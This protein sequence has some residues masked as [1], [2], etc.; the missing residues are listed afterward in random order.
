M[1]EI[2][3]AANVLLTTCSNCQK[4]EK[5]LF[6]TDPTSYEIAK[7]VYDAAKDFPNKTMVMMD[8][9][10]MHGEDATKL[11]SAAMLEADVIFGQLNFLYIIQKREKKQLPKVLDL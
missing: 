3:K 7:L 5:I 11:V 4:E 10:S 1:H 8:E 9:R 2:P 6:V